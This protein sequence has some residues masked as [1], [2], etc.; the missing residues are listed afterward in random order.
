VPLTFEGLFSENVP[1]SPMTPLAAGS[2][3]FY[4]FFSAMGVT[5]KLLRLTKRASCSDGARLNTFGK[6]TVSVVGS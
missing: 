2:Y 5:S 3:G 1:T 6:T 4:S